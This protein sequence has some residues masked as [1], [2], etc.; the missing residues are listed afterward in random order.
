MKKLLIITMTSM[1]FGTSFAKEYEFTCTTTFKVNFPRDMDLSTEDKVNMLYALPDAVCG[2]L[3]MKIDQSQGDCRRLDNKI[4][5]GCLKKGILFAD[6]RGDAF[7]KAQERC[8]IRP[9]IKLNL[10]DEERTTA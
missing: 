4:Q 8:L 2:S 9:N 3:D 1:F 7:I 10:T 6:N 5:F